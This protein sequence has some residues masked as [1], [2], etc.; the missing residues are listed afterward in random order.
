LFLG[1]PLST[2][3]MQEALKSGI[4]TAKSLHFATA[5]DCA[6]EMRRL[7]K[8]GDLVLLKASRGVG[9][10]KVMDALAHHHGNGVV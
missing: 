1:G 10:E 8:P 4:D 6:S 2:Q 9:L 3:T 7:L 5:D